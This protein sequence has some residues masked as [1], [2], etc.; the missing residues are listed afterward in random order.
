MLSPSGLPWRLQSESMNAKKRQVDEFTYP[1][2]DRPV[3]IKMGDNTR[4]SNVQECQDA[5]GNLERFPVIG[6]LAVFSSQGTTLRVACCRL[7]FRIPVVIKRLLES[8]TADGQGKGEPN[9]RSAWG[10][11]SAMSLCATDNFLGDGPIVSV[12]SMST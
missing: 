7:C 6:V 4:V 1:L 10:Q 9:T 12:R 8:D 2:N 3:V 11:L 5:D